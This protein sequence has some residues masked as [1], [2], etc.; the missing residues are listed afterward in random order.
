MCKTTPCV[1]MNDVVW[2]NLKLTKLGKF[3][4]WWVINCELRH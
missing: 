4:S 1:K 3:D 2:V